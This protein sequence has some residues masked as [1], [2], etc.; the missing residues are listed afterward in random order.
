MQFWKFR[1]RSNRER[2]CVESFVKKI[3]HDVEVNVP[4]HL[5][6]DQW[7]QFEEFPRF[8][9]G[10]MEVRQEDDKRL[11]WRAEI[12][13]QEKQWR[14]EITEQIPDVRIVWHSI[15][16]IPNS[17]SVAFKALDAQ[18][19]SVTL[20]ITYEPEGLVETAGDVLG[21]FS[22]RV[23]GDLKR[24]RDFIEERGRPT[25]SWRR[26]PA[27]SSQSGIGE[28]V[29]P[30][31]TSSSL[32]HTSTRHPLSEEPNLARPDALE[33]NKEDDLTPKG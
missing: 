19:T 30:V 11:F 23:K 12:A 25:G 33:T 2:R 28:E 7:T 32:F 5:V 4:L 9:E 31:E 17:G 13:G 15:D 16:G 20:K 22:H 14:A 10:V 26:H 27:E 6:Y 3:I 8:M 18:R 21:V 29:P 1:R 24:F